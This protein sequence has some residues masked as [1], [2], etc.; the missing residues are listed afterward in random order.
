MI[1]PRLRS[2]LAPLGQGEFSPDAP[3]RFR[4]LLDGLLAHDHYMVAADFDAYWRAQRNVDVL[5]CDRNA[6]WRR[7]VLNMSGMGWF[8]SDRTIGEYASEVWKV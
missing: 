5:W 3:D 1:S 6:W 2:V 8:S 7:S 4:G